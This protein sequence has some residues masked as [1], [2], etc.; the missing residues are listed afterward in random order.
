MY[1]YV[2]L[3]EIGM[4]ML[5]AIV[6][7]WNDY[8]FSSIPFPPCWL[9]IHIESIFGAA[10]LHK[11]KK[12]NE[13][14]NK[15]NKVDNSPSFFCFSCPFPSTFMH[16]NK[17]EK[18]IKID[19]RDTNTHII[20]YISNNMKSLLVI[21]NQWREHRFILSFFYFIFFFANQFFIFSTIF[22]CI[23]RLDEAILYFQNR[24]LNAILQILKMEKKKNKLWRM[25][26]E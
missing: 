17:N 18:K 11:K 1:T 16:N 5:N 19:C 8:T 13:N 24:A 15:L 7:N 22:F 23:G 21:Q 4:I 6:K 20:Y 2:I 12:L 25:E 26:I 14:E 9:N 3:F 10:I